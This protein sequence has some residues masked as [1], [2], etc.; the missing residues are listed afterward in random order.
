MSKMGRLFLELTE[1]AQELGY[2]SIEDA[3]RHGYEVFGDKLYLTAEKALQNEKDKQLDKLDEVITYIK[4]EI[5]DG[6]ADIEKK[7][8]AYE[9]LEK[10]AD[11]EKY[12]KE[13]S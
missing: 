13:R 8:T 10:L 5:A 4:D 11:V 12:I 2:E 6:I 3:E 7:N 9:L 1:Q